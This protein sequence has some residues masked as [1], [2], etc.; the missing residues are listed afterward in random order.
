MR[1]TQLISSELQ[2]GLLFLF[3]YVWSILMLNHAAVTC[4]TYSERKKNI[5][6]HTQTKISRTRDV[7]TPNPIQLANVIG[8]SFPYSF[9]YSLK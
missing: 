7:G 6:N 2:T 3:E 9:L 5:C 8:D 4:T 1:S